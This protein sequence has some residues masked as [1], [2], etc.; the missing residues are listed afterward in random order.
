M[1]ICQYIYAYVHRHPLPPLFVDDLIERFQGN[2]EIRISSLVNLLICHIMNV[3]DATRRDAKRRIGEIA[4]II[5]RA[6]RGA[7]IRK[8]VARFMLLNLRTGQSKYAW[9]VKRACTR[10]AEKSDFHTSYERFIPV[11]SLLS[12]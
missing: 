7:L 1:C 12:R 3:A 8:S 6:A 9:H 5:L 2:C 11:D 10:N 4:R